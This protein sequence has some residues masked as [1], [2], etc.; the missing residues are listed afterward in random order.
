MPIVQSTINVPDL[1]AIR[2]GKGITLTQIADST[3]ISLPYLRAIE[4]GD[5]KK[6]PGGVFATSYIRQYAQAIDYS[7][8]DLLACYRSVVPA[9]EEAL[10]PPRPEPRKG[11]VP[12]LL[13]FLAGRA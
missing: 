8:W 13:R 6:L 3:K 7:E 9:E 5:F 12:T 4:N 11:L 10:A 1:A 2:S